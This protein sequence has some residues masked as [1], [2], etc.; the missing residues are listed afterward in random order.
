MKFLDRIILILILV[1][2]LGFSYLV[3]DNSVN[4][5][6]E[7]SFNIDNP[8]QLKKP[9]N[10]FSSSSSLIPVITYKPLGLMKASWYG[11]GF[12]GRLTANGEIYN[13]FELTAAHKSM[14]F[15]TLLK[16]T[17]PDNNK[18]VIVR[19]NDRGPYV[20]DRELD[21]SFASAKALGIVKPGV[22]RLKVEL[23]QISDSIDFFNN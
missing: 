18:S 6:A 7:K 5:D 11:P 1:S 16:L 13:Q 17:N 3:N 14:K 23:I 20:G 10:D 22:K 15:G 8:S 9:N 2:L 19:I 4:F 21:L 12:H